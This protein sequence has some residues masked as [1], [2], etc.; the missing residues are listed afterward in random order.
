[1]TQNLRQISVVVK[2]SGFCTSDDMLHNIKWHHTLFSLEYHHS[3]EATKLECSKEHSCC[4]IC[5]TKI[6]KFI[7]A[8]SASKKIGHVNAT[9]G[10][11]VRTNSH[12]NESKKNQK[13]SHLCDFHPDQNSAHANKSLKRG[14]F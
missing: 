7:R 4:M 10:S 11:A 8:G 14:D 12:V 9:S 6:G 1:M 3:H 2:I 13:K 5:D